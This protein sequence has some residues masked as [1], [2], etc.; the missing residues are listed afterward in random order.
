MWIYS[1]FFS[2]RGS[3]TNPC[4]Y[5][6]SSRLRSSLRLASN[7]HPNDSLAGKT[8]CYYEE[9][10]YQAK[11]WDKPG[12]GIIQSARPAHELFFTH[13]FIVTNLIECFSPKQIVQTYQKRG[14]MENY[15]KEAKS[16]FSLDRLSSHGFEVNEVR[17]MLSLLTYNLTHWLRTLTFPEKQKNMRIE[18]MRTRIVKMASKWVRS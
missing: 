5:V 7:L 8:Q 6:C 18:T 1:F 13:T 3:Q 9:I 12:K 14:M 10:Y 2:T 17:L 16:G 11:S 4:R 15:F